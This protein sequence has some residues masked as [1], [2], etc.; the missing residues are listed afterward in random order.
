MFSYLFNNTEGGAILPRGSSLVG[1]D[2]R[3]TV[4]RPLYV[5]DPA[6]RLEKRSAI[7]NVT[8]ACYFWQF[9]IK[10]GDL[11]PSSPLYDRNEG[12][13]KVYYQNGYWD[14]LAV[15]N[16]SHH[17]LTVFEYADKEEL[18]L[19]YQKIAKLSISINQ[20]LTILTNLLLE[21]RKPELL[22]LYQTFALL[23]VLSVLIP[24]Q[25]EP[26]RLKSLQ[27]STMVILRT[28]SLLLRTMV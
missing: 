3:R 6:D 14:Q 9:T 15:P 28:S 23:R 16:Y 21:F 19:Y 22:V 11:E 20:Q 18:G 12:V 24:H 7:F 26:S 4:V 13:G 17:K 10:D 2:L 27:K 8:G 25:Q 1:Y 5:P